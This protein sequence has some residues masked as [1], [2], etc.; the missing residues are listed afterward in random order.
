MTHYVS[1][2]GPVNT[3]GPA[4][5]AAYTGTAFGYLKGA[6]TGGVDLLAPG[7]LATASRPDA[8]DGRHGVIRG[9]TPREVI[10]QIET[11]TKEEFEQINCGFWGGDLCPRVI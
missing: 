5:T 7:S 10:T 1:R 6:R 3:A 11:V 9:A 2:G 4:K 8:G